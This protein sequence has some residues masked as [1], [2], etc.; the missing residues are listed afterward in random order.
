MLAPLWDTCI[1]QQ[2]YSAFNA[3]AQVV[4]NIQSVK[5]MAETVDR[6]LSSWR[7]NHSVEY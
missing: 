4:T 2:H 5:Q 3:L 6:H 1:Q 7:V